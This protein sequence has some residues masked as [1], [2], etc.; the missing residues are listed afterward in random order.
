MTAWVE[1]VGRRPVLAAIAGAVSIASSAVLVRLAD[2]SPAT[3]A[4]FRCVYAL[5]LLVLLAAG[6]RRRYGP[7]P[8]RARR[9]AHLAGLCFAA[10]LVLY[11]YTIGAVGAGL[12]TVLGN[13]QVVVVALVAWA[14]LGERP[15][16]RMLVAVPVVL[17]GVVLLSGVIGSGAYGSQPVLGAVFGVGT[18][19]SY[20]AF[21]LL[22][23][24]GNTDVRR[25][26]GPLAGA[27]LVGAVAAIAIGAVFG[28]VDLVPA[29][30]AHGWLV[31]L[32]LSAQV[33]GWLLLS[34]SLPR[35]PAALP[36]LLLLIQPVGALMLGAL[37]LGEAP[38]AVQ[39][40]GVAVVLAGVVYATTGRRR[41]LAEAG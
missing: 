25:P 39:L 27:T 38:S 3:A 17:L 28:G 9:L 8:P 19:I 29:W 41:V 22:L 18:S 21:I 40:A 16:Q 23:R 2:V 12:A 10:D 31:A 30:P 14:L 26:A 13:L 32:A 33:L 4:V 34:V 1:V 20:A 6:E 35:L 24:Q 37:L 5:P 11:H 36:S 15:E 7:R